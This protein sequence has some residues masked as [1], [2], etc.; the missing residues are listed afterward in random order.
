LISLPWLTSA[1]AR[2]RAS[3]TI[4]ELNAPQSPRSAVHTTSRWTWSLPVPASSFGAESTSVTAAAML[5]STLSM[6]S[7]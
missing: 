1:L 5:P 7:A 6:C 2:S 4:A 3:R